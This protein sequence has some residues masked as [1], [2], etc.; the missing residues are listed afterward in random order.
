M[1]QEFSADHD[2]FEDDD[3]KH[4]QGLE[5]QDTA[6]ES[7]GKTGN[8]TSAPVRY[9]DLNADLDENGELMIMSPVPASAPDPAGSTTVQTETKMT[10]TSETKDEELSDWPMPNLTIDPVQLAQL[11]RRIDEEEE[12]DYDAEG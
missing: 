6:G 7:V 10:I 12:E 3:I 2:K 5:R 8:T 1:N 9:F 4:N 11:S